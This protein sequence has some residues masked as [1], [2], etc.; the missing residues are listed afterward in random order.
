MAKVSSTIETITP[1][2]AESWLEKNKDNRP[3]RQYHCDALAKEMS[4][5][6]WHLNGEA[7]VF[8]YDG[9]LLDGQH[10]LWACWS[11]AQTFESVVVRGV[12]PEAF[13]SIDSGMKRSAADVLKK[14]GIAYGKLTAA[15]LRLIHFYE[16][17]RKNHLILARMSN[18]ETLALTHRYD[19]G[20]AVGLIGPNDALSK[21]CPQSVLVAFAYFALKSDNPADAYEFIDAMQ[22]GAGMEEYDPRL[23]CRNCFINFKIRKVRQS[24]RALLAMLIKT[25]NARSEGRT[26]KVLMFREDEEFPEFNH[27]AIRARKKAA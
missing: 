19:I 13:A 7:I 26:F 12:A 23:V 10:R 1:K 20:A 2:M 22:S 25:W 9:N 3:T 27:L 6:R 5:G 4:E 16:T 21:I 15:A 14:A 17:G 11:H 18:A 8:D 24:S